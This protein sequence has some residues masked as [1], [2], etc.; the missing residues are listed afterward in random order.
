MLPEPKVDD[1]SDRTSTR[2]KP[3][4]VLTSLDD[5]ER[6][7]REPTVAARLKERLTR[8]TSRPETTQVEPRKTEGINKNIP[9]G[10]ADLLGPRL[11]ELIPAHVDS[12][13]DMRLS[14]AIADLTDY[15]VT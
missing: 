8:A 4:G 12:I 13:V 9:G 2:S 15:L 11:G 10:L 14:T 1:V 3:Q 6:I 7:R 5:P